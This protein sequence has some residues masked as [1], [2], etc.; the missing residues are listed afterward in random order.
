MIPG[1]NAAITPVDNFFL[2][3]WF[4]ITGVKLIETQEI[5][6]SSLVRT[7]NF[8]STVLNGS[9]V[10]GFVFS[11][12]VYGLGSY[13]F[14]V[15]NNVTGAENHILKLVEHG[16]NVTSLRITRSGVSGTESFLAY[17]TFGV[18][19]VKDAITSGSCALFML[20]NGGIEDFT[21]G[22]TKGIRFNAGSSPSGSPL[23]RGLQF[24]AD[25]SNAANNNSIIFTR[26]WAD[27]GG[28]RAFIEFSAVRN[29]WRPFFLNI[30]TT[31]NPEGFLIDRNLSIISNANATF[32]NITG[33]N[34][35]ATGNMTIQNHLRLETNKA[36]VLNTD[37]F[38]KGL[39]NKPVQIRYVTP[40]YV[41]FEV[42]NMSGIILPVN[43]SIAG[44]TSVQNR[45]LTIQTK[46]NSPTGVMRDR[47]YFPT[48]GWDVTSVPLVFDSAYIRFAGQLAAGGTP[49]S[50][51]NDTVSRVSSRGIVI[52]SSEGFNVD[53]NGVS[54]RFRI[55]SNNTVG[56]KYTM[57]SKNV[58]MTDLKASYVGGS[59]YACI[60]D[61]GYITAQEVA[62]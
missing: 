35:N 45:T 8:S 9:A 51:S 28:S 22:S 43:G 44:G 1:V 36:L 26:N 27:D 38:V 10:R 61:N 23:L 53:I 40:G 2:R 15:K 24:T 34:I 21:A 18:N 56:I 52:T 37:R 30:S 54:D 55:L 6:V 3:N 14:V 4:N 42:G 31:S 48:E 46:T 62:C 19:C 58:T 41:H 60:D 20:D 49:N 33:E 16:T 59:A 47:I 39:E 17:N 13:Y 25:G 50:T 12:D 5:N 32:K 11:T 7:G 29:L 57:E